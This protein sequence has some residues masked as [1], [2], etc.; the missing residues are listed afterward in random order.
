M[1]TLS[2]LDSITKPGSAGK[3]NEDQFGHT[4]HCAF[5]ID[6]AT[7]IGDDFIVSSH[8][9]DAAWLATFAKVHFEEMLRPGRSMPDIVRQTNTL[10]H[11]IASFA[12][13]GQTIPDWNMPVAGFQALRIEASQLFAHGLGDCMLYLLDE[14]GNL[15][16][17]TGIPDTGGMEEKRAAEAIARL[18]GLSDDKTAMADEDTL[19]T[20]RA[21]RATYNKP[22]GPVWTLGVEPKAADHLASKRIHAKLPARGLLATD[23]FSALIDKYKRYAPSELIDIACKRGLE[24]LAAELRHIEEVEDPMGKNYP[25]MKV[26]DDAT[27]IVFE[28]TSQS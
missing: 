19:K 1:L 9:S 27:A 5:V 21:I 8:D 4:A 11:K 20:D 15:I 22:E 25:R 28:V 12:A 23:G 6:G 7:G 13:D 16:T 2:I 26:S 24:E 17:E 3:A 10:A 18:G 14:G